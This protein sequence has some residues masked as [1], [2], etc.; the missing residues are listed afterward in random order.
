L[1]PPPRAFTPRIRRRAWLEP[2]VRNWWLVAGV[3]LIIAGAV[4]AAQARSSMRQRSLLSGGVPVSAKVEVARGGTVPHVHMR[5]QAI[6]V[7]L[8]YA[9]PPPHDPTPRRAD[10]WLAPAQ[11]QS[12]QVGRMIDIMVDPA[13][14][15]RWAE[16]VDPRPWLEELLLPVVLAALAALLLLIAAWRR[17]AVLGVW[18]S[19]PLALASI[20]RASTSAAAPLSRVLELRFPGAAGRSAVA[21][22]PARLGPISAGGAIWA[23]R[24]PRGR[25]A[26]VAEA[27]A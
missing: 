20:A 10:G 11:G 8:S 17:R 26:L 4:G 21:L 3:L 9:L 23:L 27:Y 5:S 15:V 14:P 24:S 16:R 6:P 2:P 22:Y 25:W 1:P 18:R 13:D 19:A 12:V 7:T